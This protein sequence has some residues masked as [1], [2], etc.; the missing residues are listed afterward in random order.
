MSPLSVIQNLSVEVNTRGCSSAETTGG[1]S[2]GNL[3]QIE[4]KCELGLFCVLGCEIT[5]LSLFLKVADQARAGISP[6]NRV[7][8]VINMSFLHVL[9]HFHVQL[10]SQ[11]EFPLLVWLMSNGSFF[12]DK[13]ALFSVH[14]N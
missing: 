3:M 13:N 1:C 11:Y 7:A 10:F 2:L 6:L 5:Q 9:C 14:V 8:A 12:T 4:Y